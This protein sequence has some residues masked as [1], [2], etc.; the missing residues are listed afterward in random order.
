PSPSPR[1]AVDARAP[2]PPRSAR[3]PSLDAEDPLPNRGEERLGGEDLGML[4]LEAEPLQ[5]RSRHDHGVV[6]SL[7]ELPQP[8]IHVAPYRLDAQIGSARKDQGAPT[9]ARGGDARPA[10][11]I[12]E[13]AAPAREED[14][15]RILARRERGEAEARRQLGGHVLEAVNTAVDPAVEQ[16]PLAF[17]HE[18]RLASEVGEGDVGET[19]AGGA[20]GD[21]LELVAAGAEGVGDFGAL[22]HGE[23][24]AAS[25]EAELHA[26]GAPRPLPPRPNSSEMTSIQR[27]PCPDFEESL[28][29]TVGACST[30]FTMPWDSASRAWRVASSAPGSRPSARASS[31]LRISSSFSRRET[32]VGT[33]SRLRRRSANFSTSRS[34]RVSARCASRWRSRRFASTTERRSSTS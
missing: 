23:A 13:G 34:T 7:L 14:V 33:T 5:A 22:H 21:Q 8:G 3:G 27:W 9:E 1:G 6:E 16:R 17:F 11:E 12:V 10:R 19:I 31:A 32:M 20:D 2:L 24:A 18:K 25:A 4:R 15:A 28:S 29:F 30:L 26:R